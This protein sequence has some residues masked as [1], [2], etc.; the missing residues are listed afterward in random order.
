MHR[1]TATIFE[2]TIM[3]QAG[4]RGALSMPSMAP[5]M[6]CPLWDIG[7]PVSNSRATGRSQ[8]PQR[9][10]SSKAITISPVGGVKCTFDHGGN[11]QPDNMTVS[12]QRKLADRREFIRSRAGCMSK[13]NEMTQTIEEK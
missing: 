2:R 12:A 5:T 9:C 1:R 8:K 6:A 7:F 11:W 13:E 3:L 4:I 10:C